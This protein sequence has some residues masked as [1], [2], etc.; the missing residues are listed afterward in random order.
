MPCRVNTHIPCCVPTIL[1]QCRVLRESPRVA[2]KIRIAS[3]KTPRGSRKKRNLGRSPTGSRETADINSYIPCRA[4]A[5][6]LPCCAVALRS[7]NA[8]WSEHGRGTAL[9]V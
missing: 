2:A 9:P 3:R 5:V 1:R 6:P 8:A 7:R 4:H